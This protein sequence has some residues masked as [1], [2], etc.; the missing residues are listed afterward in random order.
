[1]PWKIFEV[2]DQYCVYKLDANN[3]RT[4]KALGCHETQEAAKAQL[5]ALI[6]NVEEGELAEAV[7]KKMGSRTHVAG[8]FLVVE[9]PEKTSTW[10]LPVKVNGT[11]DRGLA[12]AAWAALFNPNGYRGQKY[13]GPKK[14][15]AK[16][17][18]KALYKA[19]GWET[20]A[21]ETQPTGL[22][23]LYTGFIDE[24]FVEAGV[25]GSLGDFIQAVRGAFHAMFRPKDD[26]SYEPWCRDVF[27]AHPTLGD[28]V[29]AEER[30]KLYMIPYEQT[31]DGFSFAARADWVEVVLTYVPLNPPAAEM[32][33]VD[34]TEGH[35][36]SALSILE[37]NAA[38]DNGTAPLI[39]EAAII[40][41]GW[42][43]T[44]DNNYY[45]KEMLARDAPV[46]KGSKMYA[47]D[48]RPD[49]K[50]VRTEVSQIL[51]IPIR[52]TETGAPVA[53]IG[54]FDDGFAR[55][56]RNREKLGVLGDLHCSILA[57]GTARKGE[58]EG[59]KGNIVEA[60]TEAISVD[61]VTRAGAGGRALQISETEEGSMT[62]QKTVEEKDKE[63]ATETVLSEDGKG[64]PPAADPKGSDA[65]PQPLA[66]ARVK[67]IVGK[68]NLPQVS[69]DRLVGLTW[70]D[71]A[72]LQKAL[73]AEVDYVKELTKAGQP[74]AQGGSAAP[75]QQ[76]MSEEEY[77]KK[78]SD[79]LARHGVFVMEVKDA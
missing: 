61:W 49:E 12:G 25:M 78:Y 19:Q 55:N 42:G 30:G 47:T 56:V 37:D 33:E 10:H 3:Q 2:N 68:S 9:D 21:S 5:A 54:V 44:R 66:E 57:R 63:K 79:I 67:E 15:E 13:A 4:G 77:G 1:M 22:Q 41:P 62:E 20:P 24:T 18:L 52:F 60:I 70:A 17:K 75:Q 69:R 58:V 59:K 76:T 51:D 7:T 73:E 71:E 48:H 26:S 6:A 53:R 14:T 8:D 32:A 36:G 38:S 43:N 29:V 34:L 23:S 74:F 35:T 27:K 39:V 64:D 72:A 65:A 11:P 40:E 45:G 50:S 46:F 16:S 28:S 31:E